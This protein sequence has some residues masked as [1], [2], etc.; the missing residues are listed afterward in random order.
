MR[1]A[2]PEPRV[3]VQVQREG[4]RLVLSLRDATGYV[5]ADLDARGAGAVC[6]CLARALGDD[7]ETDSTFS[8]RGSLVHGATKGRRDELVEP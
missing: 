5:T 2:R 7:E 8:V 4:A 1:S 3:A 6:A